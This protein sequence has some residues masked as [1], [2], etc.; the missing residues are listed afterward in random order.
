M[1]ETVI[2]FDQIIKDKLVGKKLIGLEFNDED[3]N[4]RP[5]TSGQI[6]KDVNLMT[7][8]DR[9]INIVMTLEND[10][11]VYAYDNENIKITM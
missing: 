8:C 2:R 1:G 7:D 9:D 11:E 6:I 3:H 4:E 10:E 5:F